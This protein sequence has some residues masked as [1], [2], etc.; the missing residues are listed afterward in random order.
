M[1]ASRFS[2][3][4][5]ALLV[6]LWFPPAVAQPLRGWPSVVEVAGRSGPDVVGPLSLGMRQSEVEAKLGAPAS[7]TPRRAM[8]MS[9][10]YTYTWD[11]PAQGVTIFWA[12]ADQSSPGYVLAIKLGAPC[13]WT[14]LGGLKVG[15]NID[16]T[17]KIL[18]RQGG[19]GV[20]PIGS[21]GTDTVGLYYEFSDTAVILRLES[22]KVA[23]LYVGPNLP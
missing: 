20:S 22:G 6:G 2:L 11:Y 15:L 9:D 14:T 19:E 5:A 12:A 4:G 21:V 1:T 8:A 23:G 13:D 7:S 16:Q 10:E 3:V 18:S 17:S